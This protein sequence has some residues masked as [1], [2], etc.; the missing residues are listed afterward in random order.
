MTE[1]TLTEYYKTVLLPCKK[2]ELKPTSYDRL[3]RTVT[4]NVIPYLGHIPMCE[5][6][7]QQLL[8]FFEFVYG[9]YSLSTSK[10]IY[11]AVNA[12]FKFAQYIGD[13]SKN[14]MLPIKKPKKNNFSPSKEKS[15]L[16]PEEIKRLK[17]TIS[18]RTYKSSLLEPYIGWGYYFLLNTGLR[19]CELLGLKWSDIKGD[20]IYIQRSVVSYHDEK[21]DNYVV[22]LQ[23]TLKTSSSRR[24]IYL[25]NNAKYALKQI[26]SKTNPKGKFIMQHEGKIVKPDMLR[27]NWYALLKEAEV[28]PRELY[29]LRHTF[30]SLLFRENCD[31][32]SVSHI[33]GHSSVRT[34][35]DT[36]I[37]L[38]EKNYKETNV[39]DRI[40]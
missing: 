21:N 13:V 32:K 35:Y 31:I 15:I 8:D 12:C 20:Y 38:F 14:P 11:E 19:P 28:T 37:H 2:I 7:L 36:Y 33:M 5:I 40:I 18:V 23:E 24:K 3:Y 29:C 10:K 39:L 30:A 26:A 16:T 1:K 9:T 27:R 34:T 25:N 4:K 6:E 22:L 17:F